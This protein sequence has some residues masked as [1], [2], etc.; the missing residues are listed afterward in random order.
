MNMMDG[1]CS[2]LGILFFDA[3][4]CP[5]GD[6]RRF[7]IGVTSSV[8]ERVRVTGNGLYEDCVFVTARPNVG[9]LFCLYFEVIVCFVIRVASRA[10][11]KIFIYGIFI[12]EMGNNVYPVCYQVNWIT[13]VMFYSDV[14]LFRNSV[15]T[16]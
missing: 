3:V 5:L 10:T 8:V 2:W 1:A 14:T 16:C 12:F 6:I 7:I 13:F 4:G 11:I 15:V 9:L